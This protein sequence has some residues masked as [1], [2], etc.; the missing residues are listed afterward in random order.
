MRTLYDRLGGE[1]AIAAVV[2]DF[3]DRIL[4]DEQVAHFFDSVDMRKQRAHQTQFLSAVA[5]GPVEYDGRDMRAAHDHLE[6]GPAEFDAIAT[7]L[8]A[9]LESFDVPEDDREAV[10]E[11]VASYEDAIV[12]AAD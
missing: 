12:S 7:H 8:A 3:Y 6:T 9:T 10:L 5:G 2:D 11:A 4:D 1:D